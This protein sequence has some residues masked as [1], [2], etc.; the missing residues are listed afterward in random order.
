MKMRERC[1]LTVCTED[2]NVYFLEGIPKFCICI[3]DILM[4]DRRSIRLFVLSTK[5]IRYNIDNRGQNMPIKFAQQPIIDY[6]P[7]FHNRYFDWFYKQMAK[8]GLR[9]NLDFMKMCTLRL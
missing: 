5:N 3:S 7:D 8:V 4:S 6:R 9:S 2:H 1:I